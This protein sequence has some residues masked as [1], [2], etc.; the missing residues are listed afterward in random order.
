VLYTI[1][2]VRDYFLAYLSYMNIRK[3]IRE[4]LQE[5]FAEEHYVKR[6]FDRIINRTDLP[7]GY[8]IPGSV[9]QYII[10]GT[11]AIPEDIK[12]QIIGNVGLIEKYN[13]P[14]NKDYGVKI[15]DIRIDR[16]AV[17]FES[18][19]LKNESLNRPLV[20]VD[21]ETKSNGNVIYAIIRENS[22]RTFYF[23][24]SYIKQTTEKLRVDVV[25]SM[26]AIK[27]R[28]VYQ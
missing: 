9:G 8:E 13:F 18:D 11:Y 5:A 15:I 12:S 7:V 21:A 1:I 17:R 4:F 10:V 23:A 6:L 22:L 2:L 27:N 16:N 24:K 19:Q 26:D 14:K 28:K 25:T 3:I 20:I